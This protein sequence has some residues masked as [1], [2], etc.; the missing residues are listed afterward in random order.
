MKPILVRE[1]LLNRGIRMFT[2]LEFRRVFPKSQ[3]QI[4]YFLETQT[5][6]GLF[7]RLKKGLYALKTDLPADEEI[8][9]AL[10]K[11]SYLSFEYAMA[12]YGIIPE[13]PYNLTSA[14]TNPTRV[15]STD[16]LAFSYFTIKQDAYT[17]YY[18]DTTGDKKV[19]IAEGE[20]ALADYLYFVAIGQR[21]FNDRFN[22]S[23]LDKDKLMEYAK[24]FERDKVVELVGE[25]P[26]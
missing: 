16:H 23:K 26:W 21:S 5:E 7:I 6:Q 11:P 22:V 20:K 12:K 24:L 17:G 3:D 9:N 4:Q 19:L 15:F 13:S 18:L 10:Y 25:L 8:A 14:T 2:P 1:E